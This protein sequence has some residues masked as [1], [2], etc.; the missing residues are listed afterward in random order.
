MIVNIS[1]SMAGAQ[2]L[3]LCCVDW[4]PGFMIYLTMGLIS[5]CLFSHVLH[6]DK[7]HRV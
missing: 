3:E 6:E 5:L 7:L 2:I 1:C 4:P